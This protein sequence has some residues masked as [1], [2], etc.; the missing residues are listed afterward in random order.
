MKGLKR[1][2]KVTHKPKLVKVIMNNITHSFSFFRTMFHVSPKISKKSRSFSQNKHTLW[3]TEAK[4]L[5]DE[6]L[7][8]LIDSFLE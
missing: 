6:D 5:R 7:S 8:T 2:L 4:R 3:L 1:S